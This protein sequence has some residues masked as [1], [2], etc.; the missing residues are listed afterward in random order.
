MNHGLRVRNLPVPVGVFLRSKIFWV[1]SLEFHHDFGKNG[2]KTRH[3]FNSTYR[4][5]CE[6]HET[7]Q[8]KKKYLSGLC[9]LRKQ[10]NHFSTEAVTFQIII[11]FFKFPW[12]RFFLNIIRIKIVLSH[13]FYNSDLFFM[14]LVAE[15]NNSSVFSAGFFRICV[16]IQMRHS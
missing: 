9:N 6:G 12:N 4:K 14:A 7:V 13:R 2:K 11:I 8:E 15:N 10:D 3:F 1:I 16:R 5:T